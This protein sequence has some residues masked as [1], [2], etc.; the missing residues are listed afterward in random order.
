ME[1]ENL[2][3]FVNVGLSMTTAEK[4]SYYAN[5]PIYKRCDSFR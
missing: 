4:F 5:T 2:S 1:A 3:L